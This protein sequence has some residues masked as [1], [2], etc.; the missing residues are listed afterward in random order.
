MD[1]SGLLEYW[2]LHFSCQENEYQ[3]WPWSLERCG[4]RFL[5]SQDTLVSSVKLEASDLLL[6]SGYVTDVHRFHKVGAVDLIPHGTDAVIAGLQ[7][8]LEAYIFMFRSLSFCHP[9]KVC[10]TQHLCL[11]MAYD[12]FSP[13]VIG[14]QNGCL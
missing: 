10:H 7:C 9:S 11:S 2:S 4:F 14:F 1:D 12:T 8:L 6:N 5:A 3:D 13:L